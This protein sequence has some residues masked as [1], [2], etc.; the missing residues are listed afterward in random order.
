MTDTTGS[1]YDR[2]Q[3]KE[4][5]LHEADTMGT[6]TGRE[7]L[8]LAA[9][10]AGYWSDEFDC[11]ADLPHLG[12]NPLTDDGDAFRLAVKLS[13]E[14]YQ[15]NDEGV[16]SYVVYCGKGARIGGV[17]RKFTIEYHDDINHKGDACSATRRAIT[18]AAADVGRAMR[19][20]AAM[21][22]PAGV[23]V[24]EH[25]GRLTPGKGTL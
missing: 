5:K 19:A 14:V 8:N 12:W 1:P 2:V 20:N 21:T 17:V 18:R 10:A 3:D 7:M 22:G 23:Q 25:V 16:A 9:K 4:K 13:F 6:M 11:P 24:D 15:G